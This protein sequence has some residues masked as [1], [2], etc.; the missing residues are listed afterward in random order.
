MSNLFSDCT[1]KSYKDNSEDICQHCKHLFV[2]VTDRKNRF[3]TFNALWMQIP[4]IHWCGQFEVSAGVIEEIKAARELK[5]QLENKDAALQN[6][7][8][9]I[10]TLKEKLG[11]QTKYIKKLKSKK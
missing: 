11:K 7:D 3:C 8:S 1:G 6:K 5:V 10:K 9:A 4:G 2:R